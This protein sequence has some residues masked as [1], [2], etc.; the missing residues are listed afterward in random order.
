MNPSKHRQSIRQKT[1]ATKRMLPEWKDALKR[2]CIERARHKRNNQ[3]ALK[4]SNATGASFSTNAMCNDH[5]MMQSTPQ[6]RGAAR[7]LIQEQ[8]DATG[9]AVIPTPLSHAQNEYLTPAN[10]TCINDR[11]IRPAPGSLTQFSPMGSQTNLFPD[12]VNKE[13][14]G[15]YCITQEEYHAL[16][17]EI[18]E[19]LQNDY[20]RLLSE[21]MQV[22]QEEERNKQLMM[23]DQIESY[24]RLHTCSQN[25]IHDGVDEIVSCPLCHAGILR[26]DPSSPGDFYCQMRADSLTNENNRF[27]ICKFA[28]GAR[29][30]SHLTLSELRQKL[31]V[32]YMDHAAICTGSL[33]FD[34][35]LDTGSGLVTGCNRCM[36]IVT[37]A[38][39]TLIVNR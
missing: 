34:L 38:F 22:L 1:P 12:D 28:R 23:E 18:E 33:Q 8:L 36:K 20:E 29:F 31:I 30:G 13:S 35:S 3:I 19:E 2:S 32:A 27:I 17:D 11:L 37:I 14:E 25:Q 9:I 7:N 24:E 5:V 26:A 6:V 4:R 10:G 39:A 16:I 21:Q 15:N